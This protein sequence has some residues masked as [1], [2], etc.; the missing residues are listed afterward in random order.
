MKRVLV[1]FFAALVMLL[2]VIG[3]AQADTKNLNPQVTQHHFLAQWIVDSTKGRVDFLEAHRY[4]IEAYNAGTKW[5]VDPLLILAV[6]KPESNY[7]A[8][9]RNRSG[10]SGL[11]QV[12]PKFHRVKI[13]K[14]DI[15]NYKVNMDVGTQIIHE[16]LLGQ[17]ES[18]HKAMNRYSGG[19]S[20]AYGSKI[21]KTYREL[22][23]AVW[24]WRMAHNQPLRGE[25]KYG[26]PRHYAET[27][28]AY[29]ADKEV[30]RQQLE[31]ERLIS[32]HAA[33]HNAY[34]VASH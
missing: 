13:A 33:L 16:Y 4:A 10:A 32:T 30:K 25:Y 24:Q 15:M 2:P 34:V 11:M 23:D 28:A 5:G 21:Q 29:E 7:N 26:S 6:M 19:A 8:R 20:F 1:S 27:T 3:T 9:A 22:R 31:Y 18:Y 14:R 17:K 12:I